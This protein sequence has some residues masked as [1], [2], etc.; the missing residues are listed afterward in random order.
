M[1]EFDKDENRDMLSATIFVTLRNYSIIMIY[2]RQSV[3][4]LRIL[5]FEPLSI[6]LILIYKIEGIVVVLKIEAI[7]SSHSVHYSSVL[8]CP[9]LMFLPCRSSDHLKGE[10]KLCGGE[11]RSL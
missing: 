4:A 11:G 10:I 6:A 3:F 7:R 5:D 1:G 8:Y 2:N 9:S